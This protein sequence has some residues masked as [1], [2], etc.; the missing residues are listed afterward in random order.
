MV[1]FLAAGGMGVVYEAQHTVVRRRFAVKFL[2]RDLA[3]RRDI[4]TRFQREA[5]GGRRARE[6]ERGGRRRL[7][8]RRGRH[9]LHRDGVPGR[10]EPARCSSA[11]AACRSR[12]P[13]TSWCRPAGVSGPPTRR[14]RPPRS[15]AAEPVRLP[16][17]GRD[18]S[19][20]GARLRRRQA[21]SAC[22][23]AETRTGTILGTPAYMSP[24][25][26]R[27]EKTVDHRA[28]VYGLGAILYELL[29]GEKPHPGDSHNAILHHICT[30]PAVPLDAGELGLPADLVVVVQRALSS[31]PGLRQESAE[32]LA[33]DL[34]PWARR[35]V[36]PAPNGEEAATGSLAASTTPS[37]ETRTR[38]GLPGGNTGASCSLP[39]CSSPPSWPWPSLPVTELSPRATIADAPFRPIRRFFVAAAQSRR[40]RAN[41]GLGQVEGRRARPPPSPPWQP[42]RRRSGFPRA[43][44]RRSKAP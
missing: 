19:G 29:S 44:P 2:H 42:F 27:G 9:A 36:W 37:A 40:G 26:A 7:R 28:D 12:A 1:R 10:R 18:R 39:A 20:Q 11:A 24:E 32:E 41:R 25:Q 35:E 14:H 33:H 3:A 21:R 30:Q 15:Q 31:D 17:R 16:P 23:S 8:H 6:R 13:P 4:L 34:A 5:A 38:S 22:E 43:R